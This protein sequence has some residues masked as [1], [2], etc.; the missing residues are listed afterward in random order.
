MPQ[1]TLQRSASIEFAWPR[2]DGTDGHIT[3]PAVT[4]GQYRE[5]LRLEAELPGNESTTAAQERLLRQAR[6]L[7]GEAHA[8]FLDELDPEM[9]IEVIQA[10]LSVY[11]GLDP[12]GVVEVQRALKK[13]TLMEWLLA[14]QQQPTGSESATS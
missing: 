7:V 3:L 1:V 12:A 13:K 2:P 8:E 14:L 11:A 9:V 10:M 5:A 4:L 6:V